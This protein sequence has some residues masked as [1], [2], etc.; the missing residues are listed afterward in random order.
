M[1]AAGIPVAAIVLVFISFG[2]QASIEGQQAENL[3]ASTTANNAFLNIMPVK[4]SNSQ[5]LEA[6]RYSHAVQEAAKYYVKLARANAMQIGF[7]RFTTT[8]MT[9]QGFYF[10][11]HLVHTGGS[12]PGKVV[13]TFW[14]AL[15]AMKAFEDILPHVIVLET[16]CGAA[17][18]LRTVISQVGKGKRVPQVLGGLVPKFVDGDIEVRNV[19]FAYPS[20]PYHLVLRESTFFFPAGETTFIVDKSGSGKSTLNNLL[21][22]FYPPVSGQIFIDGHSINQLSMA[23]LRNNITLVQQQSILFIE[24]IF[25]NIDFG[26]QDRSCVTVE[27]I[28][29]CIDMADLQKT[30]SN[31]PDGL[32]TMVG[33]GRSSLSGGQKQRIAIARACLRNTGI[34]ILDESTSAL[35]YLSRTAVLNAI[36]DW[37]KGK[38]TIIITHDMSQIGADDFM[39]VLDEGQ[40]IQE[41]Y[42]KAAST[43]IDN[44]LF[45]S[46]FQKTRVSTAAKFDLSSVSQM[47]PQGEFDFGW[48]MS[49]RASRM[50][51]ELRPQDYINMQP[52]F[53]GSKEPIHGMV[54]GF[55]DAIPKVIPERKPAVRASGRGSQ[56]P[57]ESATVMSGNLGRQSALRPGFLSSPYHRSAVVS[58]A[59]TVRR[60]STRAQRPMSTHQ[61]IVMRSIYGAPANR[62]KP[63][64]T[65][66]ILATPR[67][68]RRRSICNAK[69]Q[70]VPITID[71]RPMSI[72]K[73]LGSVWPSVDGKNRVYLVI[74]FI[75]ALTHSAVPPA[76]ACILVQLFQTFYL[77]DDPSKKSLVYAMAILAIAIADGFACYFMH[78]LLE[79]ASQAWVDKLRT[80]AMHRILDQPKAWFDDDCN[81]SSNLT[82]S[83]DR[84]AEEMRNLVGRF[85]ALI[86]VVASM[87][88]IALVWSFITCWKVTL[89]GVAVAP[90]LYAVTKGFE[91]VSST[92]EGRTNTASNT[93]GAIF[94]ETFTDIGTVRA[95]T[96]ESYF[97]RKYTQATYRGLHY[98]RQACLVCGLLLRHV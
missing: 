82:S 3:R 64:P 35:D 18:A 59:E 1:I 20:R 72:Q 34:L 33:S 53:Q 41:G 2:M 50:T 67:L 61:A 58:G 81:S 24:T 71:P 75:A 27:Q 55:A 21:M 15:M 90:V 30:I 31:L 17:T 40:I 83:L 47:S 96:L 60:L 36:R 66:Q 86:L 5:G 32:N 14:S 4:C 6:G 92:W 95:L 77:P 52:I 9:V 70:S 13:T 87:M 19:S 43:N 54:A 26:A 98:R 93:V 12:T 39:Y 76:F 23:W 94:I 69:G 48:S 79:T 62:Q 42:R 85:A 89:V 38:T 73:I 88:I 44:G 45:Q 10:G 57:S 65:P 84:N 97:H 56:R 11:G 7:V 29:P 78:F 80:E 37:R 51:G 25:T 63:L 28:R 46:D 91:M 22:R 74:G 49:P 16:G 68:L 8:A